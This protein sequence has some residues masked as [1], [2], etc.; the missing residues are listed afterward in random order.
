MLGFLISVLWRMGSNL[1]YVIAF[2]TQEPN[3]ILL[4]KQTATI[5][6]DFGGKMRYVLILNNGLE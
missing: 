1:G 5:P 3:L 6:T 4:K 2:L